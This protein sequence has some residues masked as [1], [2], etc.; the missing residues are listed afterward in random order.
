MGER[1]GKGLPL[2]SH[3]PEKTPGLSA[4]RLSFLSRAGAEVGVKAERLGE[5][6]EVIGRG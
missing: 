4:R 6:W 1:L 5:R 3:S 2:P